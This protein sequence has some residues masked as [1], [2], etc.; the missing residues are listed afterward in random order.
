MIDD[1][2]WLKAVKRVTRPG[3]RRNG[4]D[5]EIDDR[6]VYNPAAHRWVRN[7]QP[8]ARGA[9]GFTADE[10]HDIKHLMRRVHDGV[11]SRA[12]VQAELDRAI[13]RFQTAG[14]S[15]SDV[16]VLSH[17]LRFGQFIRDDQIVSVDGNGDDRPI[18]SNPQLQVLGDYGTRRNPLFNAGGPTAVVARPE[19]PRAVKKFHGTSSGGVVSE[20]SVE[21]GDDDVIELAYLGHVPAVSL[22]SDEPGSAKKQVDVNG[23]KVRFS[24]FRWLFRG[25]SRPILAL[26]VPTNQAVVVQGTVETLHDRCDSRGVMGFAPMVEYI[27]EEVDGSSKGEYHYVHTFEGSAEPVLRWSEEVNGLMYDKDRTLMQPA[28]TRKNPRFNKRA[29][30]SVDEWFEELP[31]KHGEPR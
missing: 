16:K 31:R 14:G 3:T 1:R 20:Y 23:E 21:D 29:V 19:T 27:V 4:F 24:G 12:C 26:H 13:D 2:T 25:K 7:P 15:E 17:V 9:C 5:L 6:F 28:E 30:Y 18:V 8:I 10:E 22:L 11:L